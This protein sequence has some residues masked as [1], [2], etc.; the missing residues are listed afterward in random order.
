MGVGHTKKE[1]VARNLL[2]VSSTIQGNVN[3]SD[4]K[5][6]L[7][8]AAVPPNPLSFIHLIHTFPANSAEKTE[9]VLR[10]TTATKDWAE[11]PRA[12]CSFNRLQKAVTHK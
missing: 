10:H 3:T 6:L 5:L 12:L 8:Y 9:H 4:K 1:T 11:F 7:M 2:F